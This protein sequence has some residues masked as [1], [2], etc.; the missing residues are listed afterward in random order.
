MEEAFVNNMNGRSNIRHGGKRSLKMLQ[1]VY[2]K[3][4]A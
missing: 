1:N 4:K 3:E 2:K